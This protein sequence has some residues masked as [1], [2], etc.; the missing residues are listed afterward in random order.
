MAQESI[1]L[2][3]ELILQAKELVIRL[4][5][6][7]VSLLQRHLRIGYG[8]GVALAQALEHAGVIT[9]PALDDFCTLTPGARTARAVQ[10][11]HCPR[12]VR[13]LGH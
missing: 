12:T 4:N 3:P 6:V 8:A 11:A 1:S 10:V 7:S 13:S 9:A 2:T 5:A